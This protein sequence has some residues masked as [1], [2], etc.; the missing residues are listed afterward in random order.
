MALETVSFRRN[1]VN[2]SAKGINPPGD[3]RYARGVL[4]ET[5]IGFSSAGRLLGKA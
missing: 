1:S 5:D 2:M 4:K 3:G